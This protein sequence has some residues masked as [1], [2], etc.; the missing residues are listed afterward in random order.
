MSGLK[1]NEIAQLKHCFSRFKEIEKGILFGS[2]AMGNYKN[3][4]DVDIVLVG[5][6]INHKTITQIVNALEETVMPYEFDMLIFNSIKNEELIK[7]IEQ[8]GV[9]IYSTD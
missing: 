8:F 1:E 3:G 7:H 5:D 6:K 4:S 9:E 2:R